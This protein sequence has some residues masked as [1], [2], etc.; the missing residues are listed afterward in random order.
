MEKTFS[1]NNRNFTARLV[2]DEAIEG[3]EITSALSDITGYVG[4]APERARRDQDRIFSFALNTDQPPPT[5]AMT[6]DEA[7]N[8]CCAAIIEKEAQQKLTAKAVHRIREWLS[9]EN[10][11]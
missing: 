2:E 1:H 6:L 10:Q 8:E 4:P 3:L 11:P 7:I 5:A 9:Q